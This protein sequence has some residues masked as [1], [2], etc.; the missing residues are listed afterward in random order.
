MNLKKLLPFFLLVFSL[1]L[2]TQIQVVNAQTEP[3]MRILISRAGEASSAG[4]VQNDW[5]SALSEGVFL[6]SVA[7]VVLTCALTGCLPVS[8]DNLCRLVYFS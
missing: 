7:Q 6:F 3:K 8:G 4:E 5:F 2:A 1:L